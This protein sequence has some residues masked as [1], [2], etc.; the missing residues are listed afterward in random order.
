MSDMLTENQIPPPRR[1]TGTGCWLVASLTLL[2]V[3]MLVGVG[4]FLP[5]INLYNRLFGEQFA[6]LSADN[7]GVLSS[8]A[9]F[10]LAVAPD[11]P[12]DDFGARIEIISLRDFEAVNA[13][14]DPSIPQQKSAVPPFLALQ[15]PVYQIKT[16]GTAPSNLILSMKLPANAERDL[17]D[18]YG[19][20]AEEGL[21]RFIPA[22]PNGDNLVADVNAVPDSVAIFQAASPP[23]TIVIAYDTNQVLP[24]DVALLATIVA[25]SG[26]QPALDGS[27][28]GTFAPGFTTTEGYLVLPALRNY[29]DPSA[30]DI[31]TITAILGNSA[32]R[33]EHVRQIV[34]TITSN[35]F[36]GVWIDYRGLPSQ[37]RVNFSAFIR[38]LADGL[39]TNGLLLGVVVPSADTV[40][41][42]WE[43]GAY[44]WRAIGEAADYVQINLGPNP[45]TFAP[46]DNQLVEAMLRWGIGEISRY[47]I[48][49]GLSAQSIREIGGD[50]TSIGYDTA[51]AGLGD[52]AI[53]AEKS[54]DGSIAPGTEIRA[55]LDGLDARAGVDTRI[56]A[57]YVEY[58]NS[59]GSVAT[60]VWL[61]TGDAL[62][63]RMDWTIPFSL[64]GVGFEDLL[65]SDL[66]EGVLAAITRY[67]TQIPAAP[68]PSDLALRWRIEGSDGLI[69]EIVT[70]LSE[71]I[72]VT[73]AAPDGNYAINVAVIGVGEVAISPRSGVAVALFQPTATP[74][75]LPSPTPTM[76]PSPTPTLSAIVPTAPF[77]GGAPSGGNFGANRPGPGSINLTGF[78]YG[79]HVTSAGSSRAIGAMQRA[80][81]TWMKV[82]VRYSR[83]ASPAPVANDINV[84]HQNGFKILVGTVGSPSD[85]QNGGEG[86]LN[87][88]A[89]WLAG[90]AAAGADAIEV[91]NEPNLSR[92][93]PE[94]Q[95]SGAAYA[96]MLAKAYTAIKAANGGTIVISGAPAPTGAENAFPGRVVNDDRFLRDFVVA[97]GLNYADCI[98]AH[99][100]EGIVPPSATSGDPRD[101]YYTRYFLTMLNTYTAIVGSKPICFTELGYLTPEGYGPLPEFF[102]WAQNVTVAQQAAWLAEAAAIASQSGSVRIMIVWNVDFTAYDSDPQGG[103]AMIRPDGSCPACDAL[104]GAR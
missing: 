80:G 77:T 16:T 59:D 91:W 21:W 70:D 65:A 101:N 51:L 85:L 44:D 63:F 18:L 45:A 33:R 7:N 8:D 5:P 11:N 56:N 86:Y 74:T 102:S 9:V 27:L 23:P 93:W 52:V 10:S 97:G 68:S 4:L 28:V 75:P 100:N 61:T 43:T 29:A 57:P 98:G 71:D 96:N 17:L 87:D 76:T 3:C 35:N 88:Y 73:L 54:E 31:E 36:D 66:E 24:K 72:T 40:N 1:Q 38:E 99:Y 48:L 94:G 6:V 42:I 46:G 13:Q 78:A 39:A 60:R 32:L 103:Y 95:I 30:L 104:A 62:R 20:Y 83:G 84:A 2:L 69:D 26:L 41:G 82:Q 58:L 15:S 89:N 81:M 50:F 79:G 37:Q 92:E 14:L 47:K 67:K 12:G 55:Y 64:A 19:W 53:D 22:Q 49:L 90:I 34:S 25:P